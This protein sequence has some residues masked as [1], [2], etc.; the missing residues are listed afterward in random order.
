[1]YKMC[2]VRL[3]RGIPVAAAPDRLDADGARRLRLALAELADGGYATIVA[4]LSSTTLCDE[5][6]LA[7]LISAHERACAE[8]G[9]LRVVATSRAMLAT[10]SST[11]ASTR[12]RRFA[13]L[14]EAVAELPAAAI[15]PP[16]SGVGPAGTIVWQLLDNPRQPAS[17]RARTMT[18]ASA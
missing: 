18:G 17:R 16:N 1:L 4:D 11:D 15:A 2:S 12:P 5:D 10:L 14:D 3:I 9:E 6:G 7:V 8:G 13:S